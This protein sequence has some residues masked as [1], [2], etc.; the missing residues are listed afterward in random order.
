MVAPQIDASSVPS[1]S[2]VGTSVRV[3]LHMAQVHGTSYALSRTAAYL[4]VVNEVRF[5]HVE[6]KFVNDVADVT[7]DAV[8]LTKTVDMVADTFFLIPIYER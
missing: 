5:S 4:H 1:V 8:E 2:T 7:E 3:V 6:L